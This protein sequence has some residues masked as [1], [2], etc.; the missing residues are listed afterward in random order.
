[1]NKLLI[2]SVLCAG[3]F[4]AAVAL[5]AD[6]DKKEAAPKATVKVSVGD[7]GYVSA[8]MVQQTEL[9]KQWTERITKCANEWNTKLQEKKQTAA[10]IESDL[11]SRASLL[12]AEARE[13]EAK[14]LRDLEREFEDLREEAGRE[15]EKLSQQATNEISKA[16]TVAAEKLAKDRGF[17]VVYEVESGRPLYVAKE[18]DHTADFIKLMD[19]QTVAQKA[20]AK[21]SKTVTA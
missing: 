6:G 16:A 4:V 18:L 15:M 9:G 19:A 14:K 5:Y 3:V 7:V 8:S 11:K 17:K 2:S 12:T 10:K 13:K 21:A 20:D 1:M